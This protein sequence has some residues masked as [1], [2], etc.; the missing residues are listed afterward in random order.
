MTDKFTT[1]EILGKSYQLRCSDE[2]I[3][4]LHEAAKYL[5]QK[6]Q[7]I[8]AS[9]KVMNPERIAIMAAL[10]I[11]YSFLQSNHKKNHFIDKINQKIVFLHN[12]L[13]T[14]INQD[15]ALDF[16]KISSA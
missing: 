4:A 5:H 15:N 8:Q 10:N 6:M 13:D 1:V 14:I 11:S 16:N 12:K 3:N 2:D 7:E 9:G